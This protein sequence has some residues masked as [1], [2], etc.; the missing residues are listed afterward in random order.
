MSAHVCKMYF[1][2][3]GEKLEREPKAGGE[4]RWRVG[5]RWG[6]EGVCVCRAGG[7][8]GWGWSVG[9]NVGEQQ[10]ERERA[11]QRTDGLNQRRNNQM[12]Q[13]EG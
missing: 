8:R 1:G 13:K 7:S 5:A 9:G 3:A 10:R 12:K 2:E 11:K 6:R 4:G